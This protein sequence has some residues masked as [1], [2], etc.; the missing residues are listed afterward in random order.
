MKA[1]A[2]EPRLDLTPGERG[3]VGERKGQKHRCPIGQIRKLF[4][5]RLRRVPLDDPAAA[6]AVKNRDLGKKQL[7]VVV[8]LGHRPHRGAGS[9]DRPVLI[10]GDGGR[11]PFDALDVGLVH[12]VEKLAGIGGKTLHVAPL[13]LRVQDVEGEG[14]FSRA[15]HPGDQR[16]SIQGNGEVDVLEVIVLRAPDADPFLAHNSPIVLVLG[17]RAG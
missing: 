11:D 4:K 9:F 2:L 13:A 14:G 17:C 6:P 5:N 1:G 3:S 10:D 12:A 8:K 7:Q 15:A 16:E